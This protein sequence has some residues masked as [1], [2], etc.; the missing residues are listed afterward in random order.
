MTDRSAGNEPFS[1]IQEACDMYEVRPLADG[2]TEVRIVIPPR[3]VA[4]WLLKL[5]ELRG[6]HAEAGES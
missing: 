1:M 3:F 5:S 2:R 6:T 4:L